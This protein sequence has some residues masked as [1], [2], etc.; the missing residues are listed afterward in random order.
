MKF[1]AVQ[2]QVDFCVANCWLIRYRLK[3]VAR[4]LWCWHSCGGL[5]A[6]VSREI[7]PKAQPL[8]IWPIRIEKFLATKILTPRA[9]AWSWYQC[10]GTMLQSFLFWF[11]CCY[12]W[13][14][15]LSW[16]VS[17]SLLPKFSIGVLDCLWEVLYSLIIQLKA[18][19]APPPKSKRRPILWESAKSKSCKPS[20]QP[21]CKL[22]RLGSPQKANA[23]CS[24]S[25]NCHVRMHWPQPALA[26][27][28]AS[29]SNAS[30][31]WCGMCRIGPVGAHRWWISCLRHQP[32]RILSQQVAFIAS[33]GKI[34]YSHAEFYRLW[35][36]SCGWHFTFIRS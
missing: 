29:I 18:R 35:N 31:A 2:V 20:S 12:I 19:P 34:N 15:P 26:L 33:P 30:N 3:S 23:F 36:L 17:L 5:I 28:W 7:A 25:A 21:E 22:A 1:D 8:R 10:S 24:K 27:V 9:A 32:F 11:F 16:S 13:V 6:V 14:E 4:T